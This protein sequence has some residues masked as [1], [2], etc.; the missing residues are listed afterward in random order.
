MFRCGQGKGGW[1]RKYVWAWEW[2]CV[3]GCACGRGWVWLVRPEGVGGGRIR[4]NGASTGDAKLPGAT[5]K[6]MYTLVYPFTLY[7]LH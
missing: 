3:A 5:L 7:R 2:G 4:F 1:G 6:L